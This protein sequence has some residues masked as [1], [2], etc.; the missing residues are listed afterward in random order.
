M[1]ASELRAIHL[2]E[3]DLVVRPQGELSPAGLHRWHAL[4]ALSDHLNQ[5][6]HHLEQADEWAEAT[7][8][9]PDVGKELR[10]LHHKARAV[11]AMFDKMVQET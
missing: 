9:L 1:K 10:D 6:V 8:R 5:A 11:Q 7:S 2:T 3:D 4:K